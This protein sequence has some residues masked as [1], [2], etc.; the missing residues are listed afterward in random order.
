MRKALW[1]ALVFLFFFALPLK[2]QA[3]E[4]QFLDVGQGDAIL[5]REGGKTAL[6][7]AGES[8]R[9]VGQLRSLKV[10]TL[11]FVLATHAHS[12]H[13]GAMASVLRSFPVRYY[14][15][16]ALPHSTLAYQRTMDA[17][18][19][20]EAH[21]LRPE[22]RTIRLG[23]AQLRVLPPPS[24][25]F[26]QNDSSVGLLIEYGEFRALLTGDSQERELHEW[27][28]HSVPHVQVVKVAHHGSWNGTPEEWAQATRPDVAVISV[29]PNNFDHPSQSAIGK[30][31]SVGASVHRTDQE[32]TI[33]IVAHRDG[34]FSVNPR[35]PPD[36]SAFL[37][38]P[39]RRPMHAKRP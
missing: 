11:D 26:E 3:L 7:D 17:L 22:S 15:D 30:W 36:L 5:I 38:R 1:L 23:S 10:E 13:I 25:S 29:G 6:V 4:L 8:P 34:S 12:D 20:S 16:N 32:G 19:E 21:Y 2:G 33:R 14:M 27:L 18:R 39:V 28:K 24:S 9:I 37:R 31:E 35:P